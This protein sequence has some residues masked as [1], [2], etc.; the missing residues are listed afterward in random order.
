V[1]VASPKPASQGSL[2]GFKSRDSPAAWRCVRH[3][4][5]VR[6]WCV[7]SVVNLLRSRPHHDASVQVRR[8]RAGQQ[9]RRCP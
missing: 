9:G 4:R 3:V 7:R 5:R 1:Q 2:R 8:N 6:H